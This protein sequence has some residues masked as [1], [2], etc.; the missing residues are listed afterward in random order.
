MHS[1]F[2]ERFTGQDQA[3]NDPNIDG[4]LVGRNIGS[5]SADLFNP[6]ANKSDPIEPENH[7]T[8]GECR[9]ARSSQKGYS[10]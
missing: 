4:S 6:T 10:K 3:G 1:A 7:Y 8:I 9:K 5:E 2:P